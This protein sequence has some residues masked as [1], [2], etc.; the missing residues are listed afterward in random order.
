MTQNDFFVLSPHNQSERGGRDV[1]LGTIF[2]TP[3]GQYAA[4]CG[5]HDSK[6]I[7]IILEDLEHLLK[8]NNQ[9]YTVQVQLINHADLNDTCLRRIIQW[10]IPNNIKKLIKEL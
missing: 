1:K 8:N 6:K 10:V 7:G 3:R 9:K 2:R 4:F 5:Y